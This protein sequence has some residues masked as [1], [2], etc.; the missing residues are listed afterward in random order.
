MIS[1]QSKLFLGFGLA[2]SLLLLA[3]A[4]M[5]C[6]SEEGDEGKL[7]VVTTVSPITS[8]VENIGGDRI[9][10]EG[11][12]PEGV[13]S[14]V[15]EPQPSLA[16]VMSDADLV[17]ANGLFLEEPTL[18]LAE[19][20]KKESAPILLL[21]DNTITREQWQFDFSFPESEGHPNPHLWPDPN[22]SLKYAELTQAQLASLDPDNADYYDGNLQAFRQ[23]I[24]SLDA[25]IKEAVATIPP[26]N[27]R[28]LTYH[29]SWAYFALAYGLEVT[30]AI[31]PSSFS[32]P[33]A[34]EIADIIDQIKELRL[35][36]IFGSEEFPSGVLETIAREGNTVYIDELA[37]DDLPGA[38]GDPQH[39]YLGLMRRNIQIIIP[40]L[41]GNAD[42]LD[43]IDVSP[44]FEGD[45][46]A[47]YPQ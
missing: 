42:A 7:K 4:T 24:L 9:I 29:D 27:R 2:L 43:S 17:I 18:N 40:A 19:A 30:G 32:E 14:H 15:F 16:R 31:Q 47:V 10:L 46:S 26:E 6:N 3:A 25:A 33:S 44:V 35:P 45:S 36:A 20:N 5:G 22:L 12:V 28:L 39:S 34:R 41:G 21:G 38:P 1:Q 37:D 8:I 23:R 13:N 11:V